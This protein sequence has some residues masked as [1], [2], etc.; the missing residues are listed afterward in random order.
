MH[1][2]FRLTVDG[3]PQ[4]RGVTLLELMVVMAI[5]GLLLALT[6]PA[7]QS[8]RGAARKT[9]CQNH[10]RQLALAIDQFESNQ[11]R[12]PVNYL[13]G[14][15]GHGPDS[16]AW[17]FWIEVLPLLDLGALLEE[18]NVP[19]STLRESGIADR[20]IPI[21]LCPSD[22]FSNQ[23]ARFDAGN[24]LEHDFPVGQ[25]N[26]KGVLGANWGADETQKWTPAESGTRWPNP[27]KKGNYDGLNHGDGLFS[28]ISWRRPLNKDR[29]L[30]GTSQTFLLGE[31]LPEFDAYCSWPY[32]NN[33]HSTCAI[34]PNQLTDDDPRDW[35][36]T[37]S[38][39]S[40]HTGG[41]FFAF[42]DGSVRFV[43]QEIDLQV[44]RALATIAGSEVVEAP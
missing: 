35:P 43:K 23:G 19:N 42:V 14:P 13:F 15:Y 32:G 5:I 36:N 33:V 26:Y 38:F 37:Q 34:P 11:G 22:P 40:R 25:L 7:V 27:S 3:H 21:F 28:R 9:T 39:R 12:Y 8:V 16:K 18:G 31:A 41:L 6:L 44:Y 2:D 1:K 4:R 10:L 29:V 17:S 24:M 20:T 30:D